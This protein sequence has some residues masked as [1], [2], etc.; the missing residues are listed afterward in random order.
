M[1]S[2]GVCLGWKVFIGLVMFPDPQLC[3]PSG[4]SSWRAVGIR[5]LSPQHGLDQDWGL[6]IYIGVN[7]EMTINGI[8]KK[9]KKKKPEWLHLQYWPLIKYYHQIK[10]YHRGLLGKGHLIVYSRPFSVKFFLLHLNLV[11]YIS[12][13]LSNLHLVHSV[14]CFPYFPPPHVANAM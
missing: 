6:T 7:P 1:Y 4:A 13:S 10:Y 3:R 2:I 12:V 11:Q 14:T 8:K 9:K 5:A